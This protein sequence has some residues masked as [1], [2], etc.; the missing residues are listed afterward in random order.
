MWCI[1]SVAR[2]MLIAVKAL[3]S[4]CT[5]AHQALGAKTEQLLM[6]IDEQHQPMWLVACNA[7]AFHCAAT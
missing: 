5:E 6:R 4:V 2:M 1:D 7:Q 3:L